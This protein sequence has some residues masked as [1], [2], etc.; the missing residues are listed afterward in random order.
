MFIYNVYTFL[1]ILNKVYNIRKKLN[2]RPK[3]FFEKAGQGED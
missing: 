2:H 3:L 1:Y